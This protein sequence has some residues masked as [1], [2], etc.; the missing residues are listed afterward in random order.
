[1]TDHSTDSGQAS[2]RRAL[3][4]LVAFASQEGQTEKIAHHCARGFEDRGHLVRLIDLRSPGAQVEVGSIDAVILAASIHLGQYDPALASF[5]V[6]H[7]AGFGRMPSAFISVS[8]SAASHDPAER[9][10]ID[11]IARRFLHESG[12]QPDH[13]E[14]VAG[15]VHDRELNALERMV[16]H[17]IVDAHGVARHPSGDTELTDWQALDAFLRRFAGE[18]EARANTA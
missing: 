3:H 13:V 18:F 16:I 1:M 4:V 8:L 2:G 6:R 17:R 7:G 11:E 14:H 5:I 10:A 12:W 15:A 9:G